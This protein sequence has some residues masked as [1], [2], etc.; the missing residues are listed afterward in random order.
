MGKVLLDMA[1]SL[2]GF[3]AGPG[4][5]DA[6]LHQW[7]FSPTDE[8]QAI[9]DEINQSMGAIIIGKRTYTIGDEYDGF[10]DNPHKVE[11]FVLTHEVPP[12]LPKGDT[13][14]TFVTDGVHNALQQARAA[15][16]DRVI[17]IGGGASNAQQFLKA[18]LVDEIQI[19][20]VPVLAGGGIRLFENLGAEAIAL[21]QIRVIKST[22]VT[23][24]R[25]RVIR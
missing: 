18:G 22:D 17:G 24:L 7:F 8:G 10:V 2:D 19:H 23:H 15:A 3:V 12:T 21:E 1:M 13:K 16:G 9:I 25:Y 4:D 20:L 6:G 11:H 5:A 14:F